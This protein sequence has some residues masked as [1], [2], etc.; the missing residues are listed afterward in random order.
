MA[1]EAHHLT[2]GTAAS[3][4][5]SEDQG[6]ASG[7]EHELPDLALAMP[8]PGSEEPPEG[9]GR[10]ITAPPALFH[11]LLVAELSTESQVCVL[12]HGP[13]FFHLQNG[14]HDAGP[15][16]STELLEGEVAYRIATKCPQNTGYQN[17][18]RALEIKPELQQI[19]PLGP[20]SS[21]GGL[22]F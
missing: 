7:Q 4:R 1:G 12:A 11:I 9:P 21:Q 10:R 20:E 2:G 6:R 3:A 15:A 19:T 16:G 14:T 5:G 13:L 8:S 22:L 17:P 18:L